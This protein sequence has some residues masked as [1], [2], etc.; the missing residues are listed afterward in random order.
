MVHGNGNYPETTLESKI[1]WESI[2]DFW[3]SRMGDHSNLFH[4]IIVRPKTEELLMPTKGD[5]ILDIACG[6]GNFSQ[7]LAE[8]GAKVIAFD[9]SE[10]LISHAMKRHD[11]FRDKISFQVCDATDETRLQLLKQNRFFDKAVANMAFMDISDIRPLLKSVY[12]LLKPDGI[13]VFSMLHLCFIRPEPQY[14]TSCYH[15]GEAIVGQP[16]KNYYYHRSLQDIFN[17]CFQAGYIVNGFYEESDDD[18]EKPV[19][20]IVRLQKYGSSGPD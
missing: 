6:N 18:L 2:A 1:R 9:F 7:R 12:H 8:L 14:L 19:I 13:F 10:K 3:D 11:S 20:C 5:L 17:L 15:E 4:R 16:V